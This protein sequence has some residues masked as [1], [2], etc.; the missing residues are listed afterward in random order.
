MN[1]P[2]VKGC[3]T[4]WSGIPEH[5]EVVNNLNDAALKV[6]RQS[7]GNNEKRFV[8]I[9][10]YAARHEKEAISAL[11]L[12]DDRRVLVSVHYYYGTAHRSEFLDCEKKA[13]Y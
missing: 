1:E 10:T 3:E 11:R 4:E 13:Q 6:I 8:M 7:G 9:A 2:R 5:F 12:P